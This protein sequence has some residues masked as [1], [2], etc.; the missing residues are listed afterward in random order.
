MVPREPY[1]LGTGAMTPFRGDRDTTSSLVVFIKEN[2]PCY[3]KVEAI[4]C[5]GRKYV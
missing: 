3:L 2:K 5:I 1:I 4:S